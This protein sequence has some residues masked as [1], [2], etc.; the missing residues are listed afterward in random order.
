[1]TIGI[2]DSGMGGISV[3]YEAMKYLPHEN[4]IY[5]GDSKNA[6]YG[7]KTK[8]EVIDLSI[9]ICDKFIGMEVDAIVVACN[10]ATSAAVKVLRKKY[11][12]PIIGMEPALKP[13][14]QNNHGKGIVVMATEM[15][16]KEK[17][18]SMLMSNVAS[19]QKIY[20]VPASKIVTL[21]E[22]NQFDERMIN[23]VIK[24]YFSHISNFESIVLG[25]THFIFIKNNLK[26]IFGEQIKIID[27]N[28]GT[29]M[30]LKR[31]LEARGKLRREGK[32]SLKIMNSAG[33]K[34]IN[35]SYELLEKL[36]VQNGN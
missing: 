32:G 28:F 15:T 18:F 11:G 26:D 22:S 31:K 21:V 29:V 34:M 14:V 12:I 7:V 19:N 10:T 1:M 13:A 27:G 23:E 16:L 6:P 33:E 30:Q 3:L 35:L 9:S 4:F 5:Y 25:C 2:F 8:E 36:E 17:K 24:N 20:K